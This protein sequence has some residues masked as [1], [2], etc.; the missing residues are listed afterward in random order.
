MKI[1]ILNQYKQVWEVDG[2]NSCIDIFRTS[3][4]LMQLKSDLN[5]N[6]RVSDGRWEKQGQ[7]STV[8]GILANSEND[9]A[10]IMEFNKKKHHVDFG[11]R[12]YHTLDEILEADLVWVRGYG[13]VD[14]K[15]EFKKEFELLEKL[16][17]RLN[18]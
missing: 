11:K 3:K 4:T 1:S 14:N 16:A 5:F 13:I 15:D 6:G 18:N 10:R 7:V 17:I 8:Y 12:G 9:I 2:D